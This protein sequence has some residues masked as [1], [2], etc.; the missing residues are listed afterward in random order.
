[1]YIIDFLYIYSNK[2]CFHAQ[3]SILDQICYKCCPHV[4]RYVKLLYPGFKLYN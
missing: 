4:N 3:G 2:W 1:M